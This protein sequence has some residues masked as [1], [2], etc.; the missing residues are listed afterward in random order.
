MRTNQNCFVVRPPGQQLALPIQSRVLW[1]HLGYIYTA[2]SSPQSYQQLQSE[3]WDDWNWPCRERESCLSQ[4]SPTQPSR[5]SSWGSWPPWPLLNHMHLNDRC[6]PLTSRV[7]VH[8]RSTQ[9]LT[10]PLQHPTASR[11]QA[12]TPMSIKMEG[13]TISLSTF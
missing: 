1:L 6:Q 8:R 10:C 3:P 5:L 11:T 2:S 12:E 13:M 7:Q 4:W 9:G